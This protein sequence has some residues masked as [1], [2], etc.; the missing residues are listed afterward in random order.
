MNP[1]FWLALDTLLAEHEIIIDRPKGTAHPKTKNFTYPIDYGYL[2]G[3]NSGDGEGIDVFV[4]SGERKIDAIIVSVDTYKKDSEI[5]ILI[6][7]NEDEKR[8]V[9]RIYSEF[10]D[11]L[12]GILVRRT[13]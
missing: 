4:G 7:C 3:T 1:K 5:K 8:I 11:S 12:Q 2:G 10:Y 9:E 13:T 6:G